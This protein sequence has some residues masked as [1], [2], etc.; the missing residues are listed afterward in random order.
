MRKKV[1]RGALA[2]SH[3]P[4]HKVEGWEDHWPSPESSSFDFIH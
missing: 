3:E 2:G 4:R 1:S